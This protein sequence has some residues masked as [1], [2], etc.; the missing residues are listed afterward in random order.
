MVK[1][2]SI[3]VT[4]GCIGAPWLVLIY[5][6]IVGLRAW[7]YYN[8]IDPS[9][10]EHWR[11]DIAVLHEGKVIGGRGDWFR[12]MGMYYTL[13]ITQGINKISPAVHSPDQ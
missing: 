13:P 9:V 6:D 3:P 1:Q 7:F 8:E 5:H 10:F 2:T 11:E 12:L 4:H